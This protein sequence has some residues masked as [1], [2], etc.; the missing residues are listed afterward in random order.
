MVATKSPK[1]LDMKEYISIKKAAEEYGISARTIHR[2]VQHGEVQ[3]EVVPR[4]LNHRR[5]VKRS[6]LAKK[7]TPVRV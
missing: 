3:S 2:W 4:G 5:Y 6:S 7:F 1:P